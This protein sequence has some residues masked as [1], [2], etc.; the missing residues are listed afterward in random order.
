LEHH[1]ILTSCLVNIVSLIP[2]NH[3]IK[4]ILSLTHFR[5]EETKAE[6]D[7]VTCLNQQLESSR[8]GIQ[9]S[10]YLQNAYLF[11]CFVV[12]GVH[13]DVYKSSYNRSFLSSPL[14]SFSFTEPLYLK[15]PQSHIFKASNL[16]VFAQ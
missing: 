8:L 15:T 13:C 9:T 16:I 4:C 10:L 7:C 1:Q 11:V 12:L 3:F 14:P 2:P 6:R 5:E